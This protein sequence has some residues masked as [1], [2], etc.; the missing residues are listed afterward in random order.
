MFWFVSKLFW[1]FVQPLALIGLLL[2]A[3][4]ILSF[5]RR[6]FLSRLF[7]ATGLVVLFLTGFTNIGR[8]A[9]QPLEAH[10]A[11]PGAFPEDAAGIIVLGGGTDNAIS[12]A[13]QSFQLGGSG[14]RYIEAVRLAREHPALPILISGGHG[15]LDDRGETDAASAVRLF[16]AFGIDG[17][18]IR[19][20][21]ASR[22]T[23]ENAVNSAVL[24]HPEPG[25]TYV[26]ITSAYHMP[27]S[28][29]LF[30]AAGFTVIPWP[31]DFLTT[32]AERFAFALVDASD[33]VDMATTALHEWIGLFA[34]WLSGR[35]DN[36]LF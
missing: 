8:L 26:L 31:V 18:R 29:A 19:A 34:Y 1:L 36:P 33:N 11:Q 14:D 9:L 7:I 28:V 20:E 6:Q 12:A 23:Y 3:G 16:A 17:T 2:L 13:R 5:G 32:G 22:N 15:Q 4:F 35:I 24:L 10:Y 30:E 21:D 27:R 25:Q